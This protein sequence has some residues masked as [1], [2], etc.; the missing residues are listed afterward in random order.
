MATIRTFA[1]ADAY[2]GRK[3]D[4]PLPGRATRLRRTYDGSI[5]V[6]YQAT[7][8]VTY[9]P[10]GTILL[11]TGGWYSV[12]TKARMNEYSRARIYS[13]RGAWFL[14]GPTWE[15][16]YCFDDRM[17]I[18]ADG[19]PLHAPLLMKQG[20]KWVVAAAARVT[21]W[22]CA[23]CGGYHAKGFDGD[24]RDDSTRFGGPEDYAERMRVPEENIDIVEG[25]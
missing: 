18:D 15:T 12:T 8:V 16:R 5:A 10:D 24:C 21:L 11:C 22:A 13:D 25:C 6:H 4:R 2:L 19:K 17:E 7:D 3:E 1:Q 9:R 20:R 23:G 14:S